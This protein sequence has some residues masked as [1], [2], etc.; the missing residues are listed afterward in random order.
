MG[1]VA[2]GIQTAHDATHRGTCDEVD[3]YAGFLQHLQHADM[4]HTL[5]TAA[6][7]HDSH[8][9]AFTFRIGRLSTHQAAGQQ[10]SEEYQ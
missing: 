6:A 7:E 5:R 8:F 9:L 3:R 2:D 4:C 10:R 1:V